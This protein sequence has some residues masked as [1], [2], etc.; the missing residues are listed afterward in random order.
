MK[1]ELFAPANLEQNVPGGFGLQNE[2]LLKVTLNGDLLARQGAAVA[3]QGDIKFAFEGAGAKRMIKKLVTGEDLQLMR[4]S[5][6]GDVFLADYAA[7][8]H[9]VYLENESVTVN[10]ANILAF[11]S[12][13]SWDLKRVQGVGGMAAQGLFNIVVQGTGA[14]AL[15]TIGT[16]VVLD[17]ATQPTFCDPAAAVAWS[18]QLAPH[19]HKTDGIMKSLIGR[20]S[21]ELFSLAFHGQGFV[22]VQPSEGYP[23]STGAQGQNTT[24]GGIGGLFS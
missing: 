16:P 5:G 4:I 3:W 18:T 6:Q 20:G 13:L 12:A 8:V 21:G 2:R 22:I 24:G 19:V 10:G 17:P 7:E 11:D 15:T 14:L 1:S 9:I 23:W